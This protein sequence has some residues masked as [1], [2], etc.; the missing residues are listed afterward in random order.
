MR[1]FFSHSL[2]SFNGATILSQN[3][4]IKQTKSLFPGCFFKAKQTISYN[5]QPVRG[6]CPRLS[7]FHICFPSNS[8]TRCW[9]YL[10]SRPQLRYIVQSGTKKRKGT[11]TTAIPFKVSR[12]ASGNLP[13]YPRIKRHGTI[14]TTQIRHIF[15]DIAVLKKDLMQICEAPVRE[16]M[17]SLEIKGLHVLKIKQWLQHL[18]YILMWKT[19]FLSP[20]T[21]SIAQDHERRERRTPLASIGL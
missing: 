13:V 14:V 16:R 18:G 11:D 9:G 17:G 2:L 15:G 8:S 20:A 7:R 12:T 10:S 21:L 1:S 3:A 19:Q 6:G 5:G 4:F